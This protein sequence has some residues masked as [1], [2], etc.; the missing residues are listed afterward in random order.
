MKTCTKCKRLLPLDCFSKEKKGKN[1]LCAQCKECVR[2]KNKV[3][4]EN[5]KE[6]KSAT[7]KLWHEN[8][9]E[10]K[11]AT[12]KLHYENNKERKSIISKIWRENNPEKIAEYNRVW[13][14]NN[15]DKVAAKSK[16]WRTKN[17]EKHRAN[18]KN[19]R[20]NNPEKVVAKDKEWKINNPEKYKARSKRHAAK[21]KCELGFRPLNS[22]FEG[23]V[24]H[25]INKDDVIYMPESV[26]KSVPHSLKTGKNMDT[27]NKLAFISC[28]MLTGQTVRGDF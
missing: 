24:A 23:S 2:A 1:G 18:T 14:I 19:W 11:S 27:I 9:K 16:R 17:P 26:H 28:V 21:R 7:S 22:W 6:R 10:R 12:S 8:N 20:N 15:P 13:R 4:Y 3:W 25:H 5:N